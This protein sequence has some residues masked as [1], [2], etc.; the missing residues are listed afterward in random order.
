MTSLHRRDLLKGTGAIF[1]VALVAACSQPGAQPAAPTT[2]PAPAPAGGG[3]TAPAPAQTA[4][5]A[6]SSTGSQNSVIFWGAFTGHNADVLQQ[7][8][9]RFNQSQKRRPGDASKPEHL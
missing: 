8:V 6:V 3:T 1:G 4:P 7:Q 9:D 2:A 5:P